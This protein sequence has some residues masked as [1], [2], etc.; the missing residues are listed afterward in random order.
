MTAQAT[1]GGLHV[2]A[3]GGREFRFGPNQMVFKVADQDGAKGLAIMVSTFPPGGG[4]PFL[5]VHRSFEEAFYV[6]EGELDY[7]LGDKSVRAQPGSTIFIP[8]G[9]PHRFKGVGD[10]IAR[11]VVMFS[12]PDGLRII[13]DVAGAGL[14]R[15]KHVA[16]FERYDSYLVEE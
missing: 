8:P 1:I 11:I 10:S 12:S 6:V 3:D 16:I 7:Q 15:Q 13:E 4:Y 5:H 9:V 14:D 2:A